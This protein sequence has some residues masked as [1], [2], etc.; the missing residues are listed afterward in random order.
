MACE[1]KNRSLMFIVD[2]KIPSLVS[3]WNGGPS[4]WDF[5]VFTEH[6]WW[7]LFILHGHSWW[8][9]KSQNKQ[10]LCNKQRYVKYGN[11]PKHQ[12]TLVSTGTHYKWGVLGVEWE[13]NGEKERE[14]REEKRGG[15]REWRITNAVKLSVCSA[16]RLT[17]RNDYLNW[18]WGQLKYEDEVN[19]LVQISQTIQAFYLTKIL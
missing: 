10:I 5:P 17:F 11:T 4:G 2:R 3:Y 1:K 18:N 9:L 7:I 13:R 14:K 12:N 15:G 8:I 19:E 6:Q 16:F